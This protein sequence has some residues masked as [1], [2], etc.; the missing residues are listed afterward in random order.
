MVWLGI[1][2]NFPYYNHK[3]QFLPQTEIAGYCKD[4][5]TTLY[6]CSWVSLSEKAKPNSIRAIPLPSRVGGQLTNECMSQ[7]SCLLSGNTNFDSQK[8]DMWF[9]LIAPF[10]LLPF[11]IDDGSSSFFRVALNRGMAWISNFESHDILWKFKTTESSVYIGVLF[12]EKSRF[13]TGY[14]VDNATCKSQMSNRSDR[15]GNEQ[16]PFNSLNKD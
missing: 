8:H 7:S 5:W 10:P 2:C 13:L 3:S 11:R 14:F 12:L 1:S 4:F 16:I 15:R 9:A 6:I